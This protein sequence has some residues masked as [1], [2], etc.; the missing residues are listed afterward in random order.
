M[1]SKIL[2]SLFITLFVL[3]VTVFSLEGKDFAYEP[4]ATFER[5]GMVVDEGKAYFDDYVSSKKIINELGFGWN[6]GNTLDAWT[7]TSQNQGL[8][9]ETCWGNPETTQEMIDALVSKGFKAIRMP[10]TW[11]NY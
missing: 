4:V 1:K 2:F 9:S 3:S 7:N 8:E 5:E 10:V 6:L 11:H